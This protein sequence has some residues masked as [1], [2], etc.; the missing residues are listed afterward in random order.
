[1]FG[2]LQRISAYFSN[3]SSRK[4]HSYSGLTL[5]LQWKRRS[6]KWAILS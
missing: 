2:L 1:L 3:T 4:A 5:L 6:F